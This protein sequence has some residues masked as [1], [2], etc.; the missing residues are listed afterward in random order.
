M[1]VHRKMPK[2]DKRAQRL[3][4]QLCLNWLDEVIP[5]YDENPD[6][7]SSLSAFEAL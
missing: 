5:S 7:T 2:C 6:W 4:H 1:E 3:L